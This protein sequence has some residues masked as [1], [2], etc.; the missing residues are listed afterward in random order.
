M[1][2]S[3]CLVCIPKWTLP[4]P[5]WWSRECAHAVDWWSSEPIRGIFTSWFASFAWQ[6]LRVRGKGSV[7]NYPRGAGSNA[8]CAPHSAGN[9]GTPEGQDRAWGRSG[10][11]HRNK[12]EKDISKT[13]ALCTHQS[14]SLKWHEGK[15]QEYRPYFCI[16]DIC[17]LIY[18]ILN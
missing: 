8:D 5:S 2:L 4:H 1:P 3:L 7:V 6:N 9:R 14:S 17:G 12:A 11:E 16:W 10:C 15:L 13:A 18:Y